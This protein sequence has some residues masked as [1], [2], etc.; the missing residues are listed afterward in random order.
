[1][2]ESSC[3]PAEHTQSEMWL[4]ILVRCIWSDRGIGLSIVAALLLL[5]WDAGLNGSC[6]MSWLFCPIW[7]LLSVLKN[8]IQRPGW[9]LGLL[10][11]ATP[12]LTLGLVLANNTHQLR[13]AKA[14]AQ[15][16]VAACDEYHAANGRF[17]ETLDE[18]VPQYLPSIP[19]AKYCLDFGDFVYSDDERP[20][21]IWYVVPP[22]H[23]RIY[24]F[25]TRQSKDID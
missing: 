23:R 14:N 8:A 4:T 19:R 15:R 3:R 17:P 22:Y 1:M 20:T 7:F 12:A 6:V 16:I 11:I 21:L 13:M 25:E 18:L 2:Q 5:A 24:N 10:R 9:R